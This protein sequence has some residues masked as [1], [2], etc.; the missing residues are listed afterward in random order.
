LKIPEAAIVI[1]LLGGLIIGGLFIL[2][3]GELPVTEQV[4]NPEASP[5]EGTGEQIFLLVVIIAVVVGG[6]VVMGGGL[7][8]LFMMMNRGVAR[9]EDEEDRPFSFALSAGSSEDGAASSVGTIIQRNSFALSVVGGIVLMLV[10]VLI[11]ALIT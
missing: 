7:A 2:G 1:V 5:A 8:F 6:I 10:L 9:V 11:F 4:S 3:G